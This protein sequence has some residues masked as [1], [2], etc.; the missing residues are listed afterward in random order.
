MPLALA[1]EPRYLFDGAAA[2]S[3]ADAASTPDHPADQPAT[4]T[5]PV[6]E[7]LANHTPP[8]ADPAP[9]ETGADDLN[10]SPIAA[11]ITATDAPAPQELR[12]GDPSQNDGKREV[13]FIESNVAD[14]QTLVDGVKAGVE[15]VLLDATQDGLSQIA[16]WAQGHSGYDAIHI[17]SHGAEGTL[18]LGT[19]T[20]TD[21]T[22]AGRQSDLATIGNALT[23]DGD[24]LLY[25]C[26]V[27]KGA[28]GL[29]LVQDL[30]TGTGADVAASTD[31]T[32]AASLGGDWTLEQSIGAISVT[33]LSYSDYWHTLNL[34]GATVTTTDQG[35]VDVGQ[36]TG[37]VGSGVEL[38]YVDYSYQ[39]D[40]AVTDS[41]HSTL[42]IYID[43]GDT[44][45]A[46]STLTVPITLSGGVFGNFVSVTR[47]DTSSTDAHKTD[48]SA[49]FN[50]NVLTVT[51]ATGGD[52]MGSYT[53]VENTPIVFD[54]V[55]Q[56]KPII[57]SSTYNTSTGVLAVVGTD[58]VANTGMANDI[59][60]TKLSVVGQGGT[61]TLTGSTSNVEITDSS[62]FTVTLGSTDKTAVNAKLD[63]DGTQS[64]GSVLY[65]LSAADD[66]DTGAVT[67]ID[68]SD[69]TGN[70]ITV[71]GGNTAPAIANLGGDSVAW[72]G[73][74]NTV[75]LDTGTAASASDVEN[76][77]GAWDTA[78]LTVERYVGST[79][80]PL[81]SDVFGLADTGN[82]TVDTANKQL[83]TTGN[84]VFAT[85][86]DTATAGVLAITFNGSSTTALVSDV[87]GH[88]TYRNDTP[89]GDTT[90]R[91]ALTDGSG[92]STTADVTVT[93]D[94]IYVT[95]TTDTASID[96]S[97]G[98]S[99]SE[100]VAIAAADNTG[101]QTLILTSAF[102]SSST[103]LAGNLALNES[104]TLDA[105]AGGSTTISGSTIT[106][107]SG[108]TLTVTNGSGDTLTIASTL[109]G[110]GG[111]I[112]SGAGTLKLS[113]TS[114]SAGWSGGV[115]VLGGTLRADGS[116]A[117]NPDL[118]LTSG[119][120][121]LNGGTLSVNLTGLSGGGG[122]TIDNAIVLGSNNGTFD[123]GGS[124]GAPT[125]TLSGLISGTGGFTKS[126]AAY[127]KLTHAN[128][129]DGTTTVSG[130]KLVVGNNDALGT[131]AGGTTV[132]TVGSLQLDAGITLAEAL[133]ISGDGFTNGVAFG[134]IHLVGGNASI[135]GA[136][137]LA[138]DASVFVDTGDSLTISSNLSDGG[139]GYALNKDGTVTVTN[140]TT[141][142]TGGTLILSGTNTYTGL[143]TISSGT[144]AVSGGAAIADTSAVAVSGT[145]DLSAS[146]SSEGIGTL[147]GN[148]TILLGANTLTINQT[149]NTGYLGH[150]SGTGGLTFAGSSLGV[151]SLSGTST[152]TGATTVTGGR[153]SLSY[154]GG[155]TLDSNAAVTVTSGATLTVS[156]DQTVSTIT[157]DGIISVSSTRT[158]TVGNGD[159]DSSFS[160]AITGA[161]S[162]TKTG[163]GTL[164]LSGSSTYTGTTT[165]SAGTLTV[166]DSNALGTTAGATTVASG[167]TLA[168]SGGIT[169]AE[170]LTLNG[171]GILRNAS[172]DNEI[173]GGI[174]I[175]D[176]SL[177]KT[178]TAAAGTTLTI[179]GVISGTGSDD[180]G[181]G[182]S[183]DTGTVVL[184]ASNT[185]N[186][187][188]TISVG[189][190]ILKN[191]S[192]LGGTTN[193]IS[194]IATGATL[195]LDGGVTLSEYIRTLGSGTGASGEGCLVS[196]SGNNTIAADV[197]LQGSGN[198]G[199]IA[200]TL[201][202]SGSVTETAAG[203]TLTK[204]GAGELILSGSNTYSGATTVSAGTLVAAHAAA[205]GSTAAGT[206]VSNGATLRLS[207]G[208]SVG[209][210]LTL[211]PGSGVAKLENASGDNTLS[212]TIAIISQGGAAISAAAGTTLTL[213]GVIS[214]SGTA[215]GDSYDLHFGTSTNTGSVV[216]SGANTFKSGVFI[217][218][219]RLVLANDTALG[220]TDKGVLEMNAGTLALQGGI[221]V[222]GEDLT[223]FFGGTIENL[224]GTNSFTG[225]IKKPFADLAVAVTGG[226]L[227]LSGNIGSSNAITDDA[228]GGLIKT[229]SGTLI[230]SGTNIY[231]G[232]TTVSA[233]TLSVASDASLG[234]TWTQNGGGTV[235]SNVGGTVTLNG[236]TLAA[237][238][239]V[240]FDNT[241]TLGSGGGTV[242]TE[243]STTLSGVISGSG[244]LTKTGAGTLTLSADN[245]Y[246]GATTISAGTLVAGHA[247]ALGT[248]LGAT[249][250][251]SGATLAVAPSLTLAEALTIQGSGVS[252]AGAIA[253]TSGA[254]TISGS[255]TFSDAATITTA[256][257]T[258]LT[259]SGTVSGTGALTKAG[260]G[261][262]T[263]SGDNSA[264]DSA[265]VA[266]AGTLDVG[267]DSAL[268][269]TTGTTTIASGAVLRINGRTLAENL[270]IAGS[271]SGGYGAISVSS[272]SSTSTLSGSVTFSSDSTI[273]VES[274]SSLTL[275]GNLSG[276]AALTKT[277]GG[278]IVLS[279]TSSYSGATTVSAG[280]LVLTGAL[281]GTSGLTVASGATLGGTG[282]VFAASSSN[283][284]TIDG[285]LAP[286]VAGTNNGVGA[287]TVN[288]NLTFGA[289]GSYAAEIY[290]TGIGSEYDVVAVNG[291]VTITSGASLSV[292]HGYTA[293]NGD[294]YRLIT[295][296]GNDAIG[297]TFASLAEGGTLTAA[298]NATVL[299]AYYA[300]SD[301]GATS[302]GNEFLLQAP[303]DEPP[304]LDLNGGASGS[305]NTVTLADAA[306]GLADIANAAV[307]DTEGDWT[308]GTLT[309]Q[310]VTSGG[311][312]DGVA[313]DV[314]SFLG[315]QGITTSA[316]ITQ[317]A[318]GSGTL[319]ES[320]TQ[321]AT[322]SYVSATGK[323]TIT[324]DANATTARVQSLVRSIGYGNATPYG[325]TTIRFTLT[326]KVAANAVTADV[327]V[328]SSTIYVDQ[329]GSDT[330]G[331]AADG[332]SLQEALA[333]SVAQTGADTI[334]VKLADNST[335]TLGAN[336]SVGAGDT[337][338]T[339]EATGLSIGL[340]SGGQYQL[341]L[342]GAL[343]VT[344][345]AGDTLTL[346]ATV[347]LANDTSAT[348]SLT[349]TGAGTLVLAGSSSAYA[350]TGTTTVSG[351][352][353]AANSLGSSATLAL[354]GGTLSARTSSGFN[355]DLAVTVASGGGTID[356][357]TGSVTFSGVISGSGALAV[358][359]G[360]GKV[361]Y[362]SGHNTG[363]SGTVTQNNGIIEFQDNAALGTGTLVINGG[364]LRAGS[365]GPFTIGNDIVLNSTLTLAGTNGFTLSGA[366]DL[367]AGTRSIANGLAN[368]VTLSGVISNGNLTI[369]GAGTGGII[370]VGTNSY[371]DTTITK[372]TL[373][374]A[375]EGNLGSGTV[376]INGSTAPVATLAITGDTEITRSIVIGSSGGTIDVAATKTANLS[377]VI[378]GTGVLAKA[379]TGTLELSGTNTRS[380]DTTISAGT[381]QVTG[382][383]ALANTKTVT[384]AS[385]TTLELLAD[386]TIGALTGSGG[387]VT[388]GGHTL[389]DG[390]ISSTTFAGSFSGT[391]KLVLNASSAAN[392]L[393]L[394]GTN[395]GSSAGV[396]INAGTLSVSA[397]ANLMT[398]TLTLSGGTLAV[399]GSSNVS[400]ANAVTIT[401]DSTVAVD[402]TGS[403]ALTLSGTVSGNGALTKTGAGTLTL[404]GTGSYSGGTT[405]SAGTLKGTTANLTGTIANSGT[406]EFDQATD[407]S[408]A[409]VISGSGAVTKSG[410]GKLTLTGANSYSGATTVSAG[411]LSIAGDGNLGVG[412]VTLA[413]GTT[414][415]ITG[416]SGATPIDNAVALSGGSGTVTI[417]V[418]SGLSTELSG[419]ITGTVALTKA[420]AGTLTLSGS[421]SYSGTTTVSAG[422]LVAAN[423]GALGSIAGGTTL[424]SGTTLQLQGGITL[425]EAITINAAEALINASGDNTISGNI[426]VASASGNPD[427]LA[428][429]GSTLTL[430]GVISGTT[431]TN[432]FFGS[433]TQT[434]TIVL[435]GNNTFNNY[436]SI[437]GGTVVAAHNNAFGAAANGISSFISGAT[438][439]LQG[440]VTISGESLALSGS[441]VGGNGA[442][443]NISGANSWTG[444][445]TLSGNASVGVTAGTLSL[446]GVI[447]GTGVGLTKLGAGSLV[448]SG[449]NTYTGATTV[450]AGRLELNGGAALSDQTAV[451]VA[452]GAT[453]FTEGSE[454]VG[455]LA[456]AGT[457]TLNGG[458]LTVG[459]DNSSTTFSGTIGDD[460][461]SASLTKAG[462]GTFTLSGSSS[463]SGLTTV[464]AGT[465]KVTNATALGGTG[466]GT[467]VSS[468]ATLE[469]G[470]GLTLGEALTLSGT[471]AGSAGALALTS[472]TATVSGAVTLAAD[473]TVNVAS[474]A[475][476]TL[477]GGITDGASSF[478]LTKAGAGTLTL[479]TT[480]STYDG[481]TTMSAGV[482]SVDG[483]DRLGTGTVTLA[484]GTTLQVTAAATIAN[485]LTIGA[486]SSEQATVETQAAVT[487]SGDIKGLGRTLTKTGAGAL[488]LSGTN[489]TGGQG[490]STL[491]IQGGTLSAAEANDLG[492]GAVKLDGGNLQLAGSDTYANG[493]TLLQAGT[494]TVDSSVSATLTGVTSSTGALTKAGAGTLTLSGNGTH[495]GGTTV[496]AG[497]LALGGGT[498]LS[499]SG[500]V[501]VASG[502][503]LEVTASETIGTLSGGGAVTLG[504][505]A[506][507]TVNQSA[508]D[509][510]SGAVTGAGALVKQGT[511]SL[512][513]SGSNS[514]DGGTTIS[515][516]TLA[517]NGGAALADDRAVS[518]ASGATLGLGASETIGSLSGA[519]AV[520][521]GANTLTLNQAADGTLS[522]VISGTGG[523]LVK[524]GSAVLTLSATNTYTGGTTVSAGTLT[525]TTTSLQGDIVNNAAVVFEQSSSG[526][527]GGV[528]SGSG[529]VTKSGT[530][531]VT[532]S[533]ANSYSG[534]TTVSA[535]TLAGTTTSLQGDIVDDATVAFDQASDGSYTGVL[536]GSGSLTKSGSGTMTLTGI[537]SFSGGTTVT[538]G[539]LVLANTSGAAL[540]DSGA[541][542]LN[543]GSLTLS[544]SETIGSLS[545]DGDIALGVNTLT[546]NQSTDESYAGSIGGSGAVVFGGGDATLTLTGSSSYTGG[547]TINSITLVLANADTLADSGAVEVNSVD[548]LKLSG[549]GET[550][551]AL[552]GAGAIDLQG[553]VLT[554]QVASGSSSYS[555]AIADTG[556]GGAVVKT[557][558]GTQVLAG[559][560]SGADWT[561]TVSGGTLS[562]AG[563]A[564]L[565]SGTVTLDGGTLSVTGSGTV[566][567][568][569]LMTLSSD[570]GTISYGNTGGSDVLT[571]SAVISG[572]GGLA[573]TGAGLLTLAGANNYSGGTTVSAG[574]LTGTT[575]SLQGNIV[576]NAALVFDQASDG[577]YG[578]QI[579]G[580]GALTKSGG[581]TVTLLGANSYAGTTTISDGTL[582]VAAD[583]NL[584]VGTVNLDNDG[585]LQITESGSFDNDIVIVLNS[586]TISVASGKTVTLTGA[587]DDV[588][589]SGADLH[590]TGG[591]TLILDNTAN[592]AGLTGDIYID[593]GDLQV[594]NDDA[595]PGGM[596]FVA[597]G[598][599]LDVTG[600]TEIN[601]TFT[602]S[603]DATINTGSHTVTISGRVT[604]S[605]GQDL[606]K[607]GSGT[608]ILSGAN[609]YQGATVVTGGKLLVNGSLTGS[610]SVT[611]GSG[612][613]LGGSGTIAGATTIQS[614]ATLSAGNSPG[615]LTFSNGLTVASGATLA[616]ELAG[617]AAGTSYDQ[618]VV[619]AGNVVL[620]GGLLSLSLSGGFTPAV[621]AAFTL[622]D[623]QGA[624]TTSGALIQ[625]DTATT[626]GEGKAIYFQNNGFKFSYAGSTG[627]DL[628]M[629]TIDARPTKPTGTLSVPLSVTTAGTVSATDP[630]DQGLTYTLDND[631]GGLFA[632][633]ATTG[634]VTVLKTSVVSLAPATAITVTVTNKVGLSATNILTVTVAAEPT[635]VPAPPPPAI[636]TTVTDSSDHTTTS[637]S[638]A[639][640]GNATAGTTSDTGSTLSTG[641]AGAVSG[642]LSDGNRSVSTNNI[643][644]SGSDTSGGSNTNRVVTTSNIN[645][646]GTGTSVTNALGAVGGTT[647]GSANSFGSNS[648]AGTFGNSGGSF[649]SSGNSFAN[650]TSS[651]GNSGGGFGNIG[652]GTQGS[653]ST[654]GTN[655]GGGVGNTGGTAPGSTS[656]GGTNTR[657]G[658]GNTGGTTPGSTSTGG[659]NTGGG[660]GNTGGT[661]PGSTS[662]GGTST[663]G[664]FGNTG[665]T[666]SGGTSTGGSNTGGGFGNTGGTTSGGQQG[667][668]QDNGQSDNP[669]GNPPSDGQAPAPDGQNQGAPAAGQGTPA[670]TSGPQ[671]RL[672]GPN[673]VASDLFGSDVFEPGAPAFTD[674]LARAAGLFE[675][676][677]L[678]LEQALASFKLPTLPEDA[679]WAA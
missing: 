514:F 85:Y 49:S 133:T 123:I 104:L 286:G 460:V 251:S 424:S 204:L 216:L 563:D 352:T 554:I 84:V 122:H 3:A 351:G 581:G 616:V 37:T 23:P 355:D 487:W 271:G 143:T 218:D 189:T 220:S 322:W 178:I 362:L 325:D 88:V 166:A 578:G 217:D 428:A 135:T 385:G 323:L 459:G 111:L 416:S 110:S 68:I 210:N 206:T 134:A 434:G 614:G 505:G 354:D 255:V 108:Q 419:V 437:R 555:G 489:N 233:G 287:L 101:S 572:T 645:N 450:S 629:T 155:G 291:A 472:G 173:T 212:G 26:D 209:E 77:A 40:F 221:T 530:G 557:G 97:D 643:G 172:G 606:T 624:G 552:S 488:T 158:L 62:H 120:I 198:V 590:K 585:T 573:K 167:A 91:L 33:G 560:S 205:L 615:R 445:I 243:F 504:S 598:K 298:G 656:T 369:D 569:N 270:T 620:N 394:T 371:T 519:G 100:A 566:T 380:G 373:S 444:P 328:T 95:N 436:V 494:I 397:A 96:V 421:S 250:V 341:K 676:Q 319:T 142:G 313:S 432:L 60:V 66:W 83:K 639:S 638:T 112:K 281:D 378:S 213:S 128:S 521:L 339:T 17:I 22:L 414:L 344:V 302:G 499:N 195:A 260:L 144:L 150:I 116:N 365:G 548:T 591:G 575:T 482:V 140:G 630:L 649:A 495:S 247:N 184:T 393:T 600:D 374:I 597:D 399:T 297:G 395:S 561:T 293:G 102:S 533:G 153:L 312:A 107:A 498:A 193:Y 145:L 657:G 483:G 315:A 366:I 294:T 327:A 448:L 633:D 113:S 446:S 274:D 387:T 25:G 565:G 531:Q 47:N 627:N 451:T 29:T 642:A 42:S 646:S 283:S 584:G 574:T 500:A 334:K 320:S 370:L 456:G 605:A 65:N 225:A 194:A 442:L 28:D 516:G 67:A 363:F 32:G 267:S 501:T 558:A 612:G 301:A 469:V 550:I 252:G 292:T 480:A 613:T 80:T 677:T 81:S 389:T 59:D 593:D 202:I 329:T 335:I 625:A 310:R 497:T 564:N 388:L 529:S 461:D 594:A 674:Q 540:S 265:I 417:T 269:S 50:G 94:T 463:Y 257:A 24:L 48:W 241:I 30:A 582:A 340:S 535:G 275:G 57:T 149:G 617:T 663:G 486:S 197:R 527:Y 429:A 484:D 117:I 524:Q 464:S 350:Y 381:L 177:G 127:L 517:L 431:T 165:V 147:N 433:S 401:A 46:T 611:V 7:A 318:D 191:D 669:D 223:D 306:N 528:I 98:V 14:Y 396:T 227:T 226:V 231:R 186:N 239:S 230:L 43:P 130:G 115:T 644:G 190:V 256:D 188:V 423:S 425:A 543:G 404:S 513:L 16:Q 470:A 400:L 379:G 568:D 473:A 168:L 76:A 75:T 299:T 626:L 665:G 169:V 547:T 264:Y 27:A 13:V 662:T 619:T 185:F 9:P 364:K 87:L 411:A 551:G 288:G 549:S 356:L 289:T 596:I 141:S 51:R 640:T 358:N 454:T 6:A 55:S 242:T 11:P 63:A 391:G 284:A 118:E 131:T 368:A 330:D 675:V 156:K 361:L 636:T 405:V 520:T 246:T 599:E 277:G 228:G 136:I 280:T 272:A 479:T 106:I 475:G 467:T 559:T 443:L 407:G 160:G 609:D 245:S 441:G 579:S 199:V 493:I 345:A 471:G 303:I 249:T 31:D 539:T 258:A 5:D 8:A 422:T 64:S 316:S 452:S 492:I 109:A 670:G 238:G 61:Y 240:T 542:V 477:S 589:D 2:A 346:G 176:D 673:R 507:L 462:T 602:L 403:V 654:G 544:F 510:L 534:G 427:F 234:A 672:F 73:V 224:S 556:S 304:T 537:N 19:E 52:G 342:Q 21:A 447:S 413:G 41:T 139:Q 577:S 490:I 82:Y 15:V 232:A 18:Y 655:T 20:L 631:L 103:T 661:T 546:I 182:Q 114:N 86:D 562:I 372:G 54:I 157:G 622:I 321:F 586:G 576:D 418:G 518:V 196:L 229:G 146:G 525:G 4:A 175:T 607:T 44:G 621:G 628:V 671:T 343:T 253:V 390:Q 236:G 383:D 211:D 338:D 12:A 56:A 637:T 651:F 678:E 570:G 307:T 402:L 603:G 474:G 180:I 154:T 588:S 152:Y 93:S 36:S 39:F 465:L 248:T 89:T 468:G 647:G 601:N 455:S 79:A 290:G 278:T 53:T 618:I 508:D 648:V 457:V 105:D 279:G 476:L 496:D 438:L 192:A 592:E 491:L 357:T 219:G 295:N 90:I 181:F 163:T 608:L 398:G 526:S 449:T 660:F 276:S 208:V 392:T 453:L 183:G 282:S 214:T 69:T 408:Y 317:G 641:A 506:T 553:Q 336:T 666:T 125:V 331:D 439:G 458:T 161:G 261:R 679:S 359:N 377:G 296:D 74:G 200:G 119:T 58:F 652:G 382:G 512:T 332:F 300:A 587:L 386:E 571:L 311:T 658:V 659:S 353:L 164:T 653:T 71:S 159:A 360:A 426:V 412:A 222:S 511:A 171:T 78:T 536:S 650:T 664:G 10:T 138:A 610:G 541:V 409:G 1:L 430:S 523:S 634:V 337:I 34:T 522:G 347:K 259:L 305:G 266:S 532:F 509:T 348:G 503:T 151:L 262:L 502:A 162:L 308:G 326:D 668:Q 72:A 92:G 35:T 314:F 478:A 235:T 324:F 538:D 485:A 285:T 440:G 367:N 376:T 580:S 309:V 124:S 126:G 595:L 203:R 129:Y 244:A 70:G 410:A 215:T 623:N 667:D 375:G 635:V 174:S 583:A 349:K 435:S 201:T 567:I 273:Y 237:T 604:G 466:S 632:I 481:G 148:G 187:G 545:G 263:L 137:T 406:V 384:L 45:T 99:F 268:G 38:Q 420:G 333:R 207:G 415:E 121:T 132:T 170:A 254:A 515:A 179:S